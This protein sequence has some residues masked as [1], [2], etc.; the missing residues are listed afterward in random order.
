MIK[1]VPSGDSIIIIQDLKSLKSSSLSVYIEKLNLTEIEDIISLKNSL[2]IIF[3]PYKITSER[4]IKKIQNVISDKNL[5]IKKKS[6]TWKIPICYD[7]DFAIDFKEISSISKLDLEQLKKKHFNKTYEVDLIGF[8]P[9][10]LY[11]GDLDK[12]LRFPRKKNPRTSIPEG[13]VG[14]AGNQTG[15]Y[16]IESPG[17]W[18]IIGRTPLK[19]FNKSKNPPIN[20]N[21]GDKVIFQE[22]TKEDFYN[23]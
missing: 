21:Q 9:G 8:L 16:N 20:I 2:G 5:N 10:F 17:G 23:Y 1:I 6:K 11:L 18:N 19:L 14:I 3:N 15:I 4:L 22:I 7:K 13:S 12:S